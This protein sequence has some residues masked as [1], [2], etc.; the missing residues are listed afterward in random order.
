MLNSSPHALNILHPYMRDG[1][2]EA[3]W[4]LEHLPTREVGMLQVWVRKCI[5]VFLYYLTANFLYIGST[6]THRSKAELVLEFLC[7]DVV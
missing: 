6:E 7:S 3:V 2:R 1:E 4:Y 5:G